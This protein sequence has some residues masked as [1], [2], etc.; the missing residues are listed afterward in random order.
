M[1][2]RPLPRQDGTGGDPLPTVRQHHPRA[3]LEPDVRRVRRDHHGRDVRGGRSRPL[4][5]P[6]RGAARCR[7]EPP[8]CRWWRP[9]R[10]NPPRR[11]PGASGTRRWTC[12]ARSRR[13]PGELRARPVRRVHGRSTGSPPDSTTETFTA[14]RLDI[15]NWRWSGVPFFIR[16]GK[17][18]PVTQTE[19]RVVFKQ[20]PKVDFGF[21][22]G[23]DFR[24][25]RGQL[26]VKLDPA[27]GVRLLMEARRSDA[28]CPSRS[29]STWSSP[30]RVARA[31]PVRGAAARRHD[32]ADRSVQPAGRRRGELAD[33]AAAAR[34]PAPVQPY[35][36]GSWGP[37][38]ADQLV[39]EQGGWQ[40]PWVV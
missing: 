6:G 14:L 29:L 28:D 24:P 2:D 8:A 34:R 36:P 31:H 30:T 7:G 11:R 40:G 13:R 39:A 26:M 23:S 9:P 19:L 38:A 22:G 1:P 20:P 33:H 10:W 27:T 37:A 3:G 4:L 17:R 35:A 16:A 32:R 25:G 21:G 18:L 5:R 15:E 12:C